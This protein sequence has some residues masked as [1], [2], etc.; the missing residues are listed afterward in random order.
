MEMELREGIAKLIAVPS[1]KRDVLVWDT[2]APGV[3]LRKFKGGR[4]MWGV[5][6]H[7]GGKTR[8][9]TLYDAGEKGTLAKARSQAADVRAKA[10]LGTDVLGDRQAQVAAAARTVTLGKLI[11]LYIADRRESWRPS[12]RYEVERYLSKSWW[13]LADI[14][15]EAV[16]RKDI[17]KVV[18][19]IAAASGKVSADRARTALSGLYSWAIDRG[20]VDAS[21]VLHIKSRAGDIRRERT[22][23]AE[24]LRIVWAASDEVSPDY[25]RIVRLLILTGQ[26]RDEI[27]F[28]H[29][30]EV[31]NG[32]GMR[33][34]IPGSRTKNKRPHIVPLSAEAIAELPPKSNHRTT[35]FGSQDLGFHGWSREK[36]ELD[37]AIARKMPGFKPWHVHDLRRTFVTMVAELGIAPPHIIEVIVN[38]VSGA[39][40]GV[41]G[42]Y[43]KALH[44]EERRRALDAWGKY[45]AEKI[46]PRN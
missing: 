37:K 28:L 27:G 19:E 30:A 13:G 25:G 34:E 38:H 16:A 14:P 15:V 35:L 12:Y 36:H 33:L 26:R 23:T 7:I 9:M 8:Q 5:R 24:E 22:L 45:V 42:T 21:P 40:A 10:R 18:D 6:Y 41:A 20:H 4:A 39:K 1:G 11:E 31:Q 44:L 43:N 2:K 29:W 17:V 32:D 3:F 46:A